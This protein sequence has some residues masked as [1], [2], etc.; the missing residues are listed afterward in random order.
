MFVDIKVNRFDL[1]C[2]DGGVFKNSLLFCNKGI[3]RDYRDLHNALKWEKQ[4]IVKE[5][6]KKIVLLSRDYYD[7]EIVA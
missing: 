3:I 2:E 4:I 7:A 1:I 6:D 5:G